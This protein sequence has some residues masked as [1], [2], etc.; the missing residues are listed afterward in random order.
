M[1]ARAAE[2]QG[3]IDWTPG[4]TGGTKILLTMPLRLPTSQHAGT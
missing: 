4:T 1:R 2:L 3:Q